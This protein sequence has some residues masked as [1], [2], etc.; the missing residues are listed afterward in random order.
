ML[1]SFVLTAD[2]KS[3]R[4]VT[5]TNVYIDRSMHPRSTVC[6]LIL[7]KGTAQVLT[8]QIIIFDKKYHICHSFNV[9]L[10]FMV[11]YNIFAM[12]CLSEKAFKNI[13]LLVRVGM[14]SWFPWSELRAIAINTASFLLRR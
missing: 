13:F 6:V 12:C 8:F 7:V 3:I 14:A 5:Q 10:A 9:L 2:H 11:L 1:W 4:I